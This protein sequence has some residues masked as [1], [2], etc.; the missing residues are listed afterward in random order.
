[1]TSPE[2]FKSAGDVSS[3]HAL[4]QS[5]AFRVIARIKSQHAGVVA[6]TKLKLGGGRFIQQKESHDFAHLR[7]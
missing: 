7:W 6:D 2:E 1:M 4:H 3:L 5:T